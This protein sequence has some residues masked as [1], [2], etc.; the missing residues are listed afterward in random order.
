MEWNFSNHFWQ[1]LQLH[2]DKLQSVKI[3]WMS[4][5]LSENAEILTF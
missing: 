3:I 2:M 4:Y 5:D 1:G